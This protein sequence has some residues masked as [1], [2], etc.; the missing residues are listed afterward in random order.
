MV[1]PLVLAYSISWSGAEMQTNVFK[2][3]AKLK[4]KRTLIITLRNKFQAFAIFHNQ[5]HSQRA[6]PLMLGKPA[7]TCCAI[8]WLNN[9]HI[10]DMY[11]IPYFVWF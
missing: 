7:V 10:F 5:I 8:V 2:M 6:L 9:K 11:C 4:Y 3:A 1:A